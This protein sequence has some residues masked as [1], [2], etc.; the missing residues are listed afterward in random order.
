MVGMPPRVW[1]LHLGTVPG[2]F[3]LLLQECRHSC[4]PAKEAPFYRHSQVE[5]GVCS[6][7][8][9]GVRLC[10]N[11][12]PVLLCAVSC[13]DNPLIVLLLTFKCFKYFQHFSLLSLGD[14]I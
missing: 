2:Q 11:D 1:D 4:F 14:F 13:K 9:S 5:P 6:D 12:L 3:E 8:Y 7:I 10:R